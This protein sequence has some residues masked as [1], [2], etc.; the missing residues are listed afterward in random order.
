MR[1]RLLVRIALLGA[2]PSVRHR[3]RVP[4]V[5]PENMQQSRGGPAA[6]V[7][8]SAPQGGLAY[9]VPR[10]RRQLRAKS[11]QAASTSFP[12]ALKPALY[13]V[14]A[15]TLKSLAKLSAT[16]PSVLLVDT[17]LLVWHLRH[18]S[19]ASL[20]LLAR[21]RAPVALMAVKIAQRANLLRWGLK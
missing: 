15:C 18:L 9:L 5:C 8:I 4:S 16:A 17:A 11:V 13:A 21:A 14:Q 1:N 12:P 2:S 20:V 10:R 3:Q 7:Q 19:T 6:T